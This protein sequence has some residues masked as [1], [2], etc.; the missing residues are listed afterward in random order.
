M[1]VPE[2]RRRLEAALPV[3]IPL[4]DP[5]LHPR[6]QISALADHILKVAWHRAE[7]EEALYWCIEAGK[8]L[9]VQWERHQGY[10]VALRGNRPTQEQV[11]EAKRRTGAQDTWD[12]LQECKALKESL[13]R[14]I[15]RL[16]G[17]D[18]DAASRTYTLLSGA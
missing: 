9:R 3:R 12:G 13:E 17:S 14:Q 16:G 5:N 2:I 15:A 8:R 4:L 11:N 10:E 7:L 6:E 1:D 18:Y